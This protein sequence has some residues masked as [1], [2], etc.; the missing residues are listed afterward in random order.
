MKDNIFKLAKFKKSRRYP[1]QTITDA[2]YTDDIALL[3]STPTQAETLQHSLEP[4][5]AGIGLHVN[6]EKM[7]YICFNQRCYISTLIVSS[8]KLVEKFNYLGS[9]VSSTLTDINTQLAKAWTAIDR[10]SVIW[11]S[12]QTDRIKCIFPSSRRV[13]T[14]IW[15]HYIDTN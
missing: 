14:A 7:G 12:D 1:A 5:A 15:M 2:H 10:L 11:K 3:A 8:L 13:D 4:T 6:A 9:S